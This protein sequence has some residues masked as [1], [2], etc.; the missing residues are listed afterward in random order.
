MSSAF[1]VT[2]NAL[3]C[4]IA[5]SDADD[6]GDAGDAGD[7]GDAAGDAG[8][9]DA[10]DGDGVHPS[11]AA[12]RQFDQP[13]LLASQPP[14]QLPGLVGGAEDTVVELWESD[15]DKEEL[16]ERL[17]VRILVENLRTLSGTKWVDDQVINFY[18]NLCKQRSDE[19]DSLPNIWIGRTNMYNM[20]KEQGPKKVKRWTKKVKPNVFAKDMIL[21]PMNL[22]NA[23]WCCGCVNMKKKRFEL[24]DST[25]VHE[26]EFYGN[27]RAWLTME[28]EKG[29][30]ELNLD[31][32]TNYDEDASIPRQ[33][34]MHDC[35]VFAMFFLSC[36]ALGKPF[37]FSQ[38]DMPVL[39]KRIAFEILT[40]K[41]LPVV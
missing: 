26:H 24:Y 20:I 1:N 37:N 29:E 6:A 15:D 31:E 14:G 30:I 10:D 19:D 34:N 7:V 16:I 2:A 22:N 39:R 4:T 3:A 40:E 25:G 17:A 41:L 12:L 11:V 38:A 35:G 21:F 33:E 13:L 18:R 9:D 32:W 8:A 27:M 28:A 36:L 5:D 23:H